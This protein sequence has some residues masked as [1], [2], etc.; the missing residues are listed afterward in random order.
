MRAFDLGTDRQHLD[1]AAVRAFAGAGQQ[2]LRRLAGF[3][4]HRVGGVAAD[5]H[6]QAVD[7]VPAAGR[8]D[9]RE[10]GAGDRLAPHADRLGD[11]L[12]VGMLGED[13]LRGLGAQRVDRGAGHAGD[14]DDVALAAELLDQPFGGDAAGFFLVDWML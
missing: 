5:L 10:L 4:L 9:L 13:F 8:Q 14:D 6:P 11:D 1:A 2:L 12:D 7:L 3:E